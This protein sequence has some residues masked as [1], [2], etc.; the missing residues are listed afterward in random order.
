MPA[1][2]AYENMKVIIENICCF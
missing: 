1:A 2:G